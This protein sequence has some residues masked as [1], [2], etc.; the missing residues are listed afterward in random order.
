MKTLVVAVAIALVGIIV[1]FL[2]L[3]LIGFDKSVAGPIA[4]AIVGGI[5]YVRE[6]LEKQGLSDSRRTTSHPVLSF[7]GYGMQPT[8]LILYGTLILFAAMNLTVGLGSHIMGQSAFVGETLHP[9]VLALSGV[10]VF[11]AVFLVGRW[12]G[13]RGVSKGIATIFLISGFARVTTYCSI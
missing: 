7:E 6:S 11:P 9:M 10:V 2:A 13:R 1:V 4:T 3:S 8:R 5:P 12:V